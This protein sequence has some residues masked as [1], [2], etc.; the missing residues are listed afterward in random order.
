M[1]TRTDAPRLLDVMTRH[2]I[3]L[4]GVKEHYSL[5]FNTTV[6]AIQRDFRELFFNLD[7]DDLGVMSKRELERFIRALRR[8]QTAHYSVY[9]AALLEDLRKFMEADTELQVDILKETQETNALALAALAALLTRKGS[10]TL[11]A[12][13]LNAPL[14]ANGL[15]P[16]SLLEYFATSSGFTV[17][18]LVRK[19]WANKATT[20]ATLS[21]LIGTARLNR[22]DG[23]LLRFSTQA[24]GIVATL[25]QHAAGIAQ[26]ATASAYFESYRWVSVIDGKTS[27][28]CLSR[29]GRVYRYGEGPIPP[30]HMRCRSKTVPVDDDVELVDASY[31]AWMQR[32]PEAVQ[33]DVLGE[34][35]AAQLRAGKL[36][37][38]DMPKFDTPTP[39][40]LAGFVGKLRL[41]LAGRGRATA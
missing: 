30:A 28:I 7:Y 26:A 10:K 34:A 38:A 29:N 5:S 22:R 20:K 15:T 21:M 12:K 33:N 11:W 9:I 18:T 35:R 3:Y 1:V 16:E 13:M 39:L 25:L 8:S 6:Q 4:E 40:T 36:K 41:I 31:Y 37:A 23:A 2:Q 32:Q 17:E 27:D 14:P 19:A 24:S